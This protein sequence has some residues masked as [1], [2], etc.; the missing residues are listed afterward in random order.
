MAVG[1]VA[2]TALNIAQPPRGGAPSAWSVAPLRVD[3]AAHHAPGIALGGIAALLA[4]TAQQGHALFNAA[5]CGV[6]FGLGLAISGMSYADKVSGFLDVGCFAGP[7]DPSLACVMGGGLV[8]SSL[9]YQYSLRLPSPVLAPKFALPTRR[10]VDMRLIVGSAFF[11]AGWALGGMCPGPAL[12]NLML[13]A[14]GID[15]T[16][17]GLPFVAAMAAAAAAA[18]I[19]FPAE[20]PKATKAASAKKR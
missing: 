14:F 16:H 20:A 2:T 18:D 17:T 12:A 8:G 11:G 9:G 10:D 4:L 7:W 5:L 13:P 6:T 19:A 3:G 1:A 15:V